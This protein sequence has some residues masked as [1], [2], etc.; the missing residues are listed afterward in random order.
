MVIFVLNMFN[1]HWAIE[2]TELE[3]ANWKR[4]TIGQV[5][6]GLT[7]LLKANQQAMWGI[8]FPRGIQ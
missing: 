8:V 1:I 4:S 2:E 5:C 6:M 3:L 7:V